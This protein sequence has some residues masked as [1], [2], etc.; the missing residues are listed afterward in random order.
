MPQD[1]ALPQG[2]RS[3]VVLRQGDL[4]VTAI[5]VLHDPV[6]HAYAYRID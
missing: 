6:K 3:M 5:R 4:V 1:I 2:A